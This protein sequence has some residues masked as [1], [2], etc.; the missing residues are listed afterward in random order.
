MLHCIF[1]YTRVG[2]NVCRLTMKEWLSS[3][4]ILRATIST[5]FLIN[6]YMVSSHVPRKRE[7][8]IVWLWR[9]DRRLGNFARFN[10]TF[11]KLIEALFLPM[12]IRGMEYSSSDYEGVIIEQWNL[13][14][15][16][17]NFLKLIA[18]LFL[19]VNEGGWNIHCLIKK[20]WSSSCETLFS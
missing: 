5:F 3:C 2:W 14:R 6:G 19:S 7:M 13:A 8:F 4:V 10:F 15:I 18:S 17:F 16:N 20:Y 12:N 1:L 11:F 9:T